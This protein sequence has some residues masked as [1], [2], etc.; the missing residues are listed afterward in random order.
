MLDRHGKLDRLR[1]PRK[2]PN[3]A[4]QL[5]AKEAEGRG[6]AKGN[7]HQHTLPIGHS[8]RPGRPHALERIRQAARRDHTLRFTALLHHVYDIEWLRAAYFALKREAAPGIDGETW[9]YYGE[10]LDANLQDLAG[11][12]MRGG[13]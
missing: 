6:R 7:L 1:V 3:R 12:L 11:R 13:C 2:P 8:A 5:A 9:Q 10:T 4:G